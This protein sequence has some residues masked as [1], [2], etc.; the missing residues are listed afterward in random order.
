MKIKDVSRIDPQSLMNDKVDL[1]AFDYLTRMRD[2]ALDFNKA[3]AFKEVIEDYKTSRQQIL[4][5]TDS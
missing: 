1:M 4:D 5:K 3:A 2:L